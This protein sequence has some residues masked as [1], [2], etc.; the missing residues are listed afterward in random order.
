MRKFF[1]ACFLIGLFLGFGV[2]GYYY[3]MQEK[4]IFK[5]KILQNDYKYNFDN[6]F[7][8]VNITLD[9]GDVINGLHFF[10][11]HPKG[12]VLYLHG[13]GR[14]LAE[15]G[16][17]AEEPLKCG[18]DVFMIDYRGFGKSTDNLSEEHLMEDAIAA[19]KYLLDRYNENEIVVHGVSLGTA[20]ASYVCSLYQPKCCILVAPYFNMIET[21]HYNKPILPKLVL[22]NILK[23]HLRTDT[24]I[25]NAKCPLHI[26]HGTE[27]KLIPYSQSEMLVELLNK[28]KVEN[29]FYP[30]NDWGHRDIHTNSLYQKKVKE[31][32]D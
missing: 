22:V 31:L 9:N 4:L 5:P 15:W 30:L 23:Y 12:V 29:H 3:Q 7:Q 25:I 10:H 32:L 27:D 19:Y 6:P 20:M 21:A 11:E 13:Q 2:V 17:R 26:F 28:E 1:K 16:K 8:E 24:W 18:Y 14:N